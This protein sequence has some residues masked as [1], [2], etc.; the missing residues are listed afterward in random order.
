[1]SQDEPGNKVLVAQARDYIATFESEAG[2]RVLRDLMTIAG[3]FNTNFEPAPSTHAFREGQ[4]AI[5]LDILWKLRYLETW[6]ARH[7]NKEVINARSDYET[8]DRP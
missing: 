4:R 2:K 7:F 6:D 8:A 3:V 5:V 1:M